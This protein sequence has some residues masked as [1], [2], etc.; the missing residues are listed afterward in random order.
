[1][2][3]LSSEY[4]VYEKNFSMERELLT[5]FYRLKNIYYLFNI[6]YATVLVLLIVKMEYTLFEYPV[7][8]EFKFQ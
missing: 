7:Y 3:E 1:M 4:C 8:R 5:K 2:N 6:L